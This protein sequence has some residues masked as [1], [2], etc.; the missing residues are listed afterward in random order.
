LNNLITAVNNIG[1]DPII[2]KG[3]IIKSINQYYNKQ[4][5]PYR[6]IE[7]KKINFLDTKRIQKLHLKRNNKMKKGIGKRLLKA[8]E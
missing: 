3:K 5:A 7:N 6:S 1:L 4:L 2:I 8:A